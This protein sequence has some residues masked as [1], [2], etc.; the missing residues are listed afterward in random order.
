MN[1]PNCLHVYQ[2]SFEIVIETKISDCFDDGQLLRHLNSF[3]D[4]K[5][6]VLITLAPAPMGT[7]KLVAFEEKLKDQ[8]EKEPSL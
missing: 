7:G 3:S 6:M 4:E 8:N 1:N 5:Y 2:E